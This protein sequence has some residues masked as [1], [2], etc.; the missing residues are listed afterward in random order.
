MSIERKTSS[1]VGFFIRCT[2]VKTLIIEGGPLKELI[3]GWP[4]E[5]GYDESA[6]VV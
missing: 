6:E 4:Y 1:S 3:H 5:D 2:L